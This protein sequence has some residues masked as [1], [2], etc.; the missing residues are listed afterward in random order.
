MPNII[1]QDEHIGGVVYGR[2]VNGSAMLIATDRRVIFLDR[3]PLFTT[4][5]EVTYDVVSGFKIDLRGVISAVTLNTKIGDF[6]LRYVNRRC[7]INF[8]HFLESRRLEYDVAAP[9]N[10]KTSK[11]DTTAAD[12]EGLPF[13]TDEAID[14]LRDNEAG[15]LS[16][17]NNNGEVH[18]AVIYYLLDEQH[19]IYLLTKAETTKARNIVSNKSVALTVFD[20]GQG[21]TLQLQGAAEVETDEKIRQFVFNKIMKPHTYSGKKDLPPV[22]WLEAGMFVV[23]KITP[24]NCNFSDFSKHDK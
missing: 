8:K 17:S 14:F 2:Y 18:G 21:K 9:K 13:L 22:A 16:T 10:G 12:P 19:H 24:S 15:V 23:I 3:K 1:H 20:I 5:Q 4:N 11:K 7:A 6:T